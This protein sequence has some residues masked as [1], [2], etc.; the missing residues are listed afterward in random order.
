M[1]ATQPSL[2]FRGGKEPKSNE[3]IGFFVEVT[4][5]HNADRGMVY[6]VSIKRSLPEVQPTGE[7]KITS[8]NFD[9]DITIPNGSGA[10]IAGLL[11]RKTMLEGE[12]D[13]YKTNILKALLDPAFQK[14]ENE[15]IIIVSP[16]LSP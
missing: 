10:V 12:D 15:F 16:N 13:L 14:G 9:E 11:P 3:A 6:K 4:P 8:Q 2:V 1:T 7:I 5:T